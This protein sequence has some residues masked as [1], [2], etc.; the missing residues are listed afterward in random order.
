[1]R[2]AVLHATRDMRVEVV[3]DPTPGPGDVLV[4]VRYNGLCGTDVSEYAT[5]QLFAPLTSRHPASGHEGPT[6]LGHEF[7]GT[8]VAAGTGAEHLVGERVASGAGIWCG[9]CT[10][11]RDGRTNLCDRYYTLGLNTHGGLAELAVS[12]ASIC[13]VVPDGCADV[14][15]ALAQPLAVGFHAMRRSGVAAGDSVVLLGVGA[16]GSFVLASL[17][18]HDGE[19]VAL[20]IDQRRLDT[21]SELGATSTHLLAPDATA[22]DIATVVPGGADVVFETSGSPGSVERAVAMTRRGGTVMLVGLP[23]APQEVAVTPIVLAEKDLRTTVAHVCDED[24][25][26]A[27]ELLAR[28]PLARHLVDREVPLAEVVTAALEP[29]V[30][31]RIPGKV[32]VR[33]G[34]DG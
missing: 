2:A 8:V 28:R 19:V 15:A 4:Q 16:I 34:D 25:P 29:L 33:G 9:V 5:R 18:G 13:R 3:P 26:A 7:I 32:L 23:K 27:L 14:D 24:I 6:I 30:D 1:M 31:G 21:A 22:D 20:D 10:W 11:C 12:P 17:D